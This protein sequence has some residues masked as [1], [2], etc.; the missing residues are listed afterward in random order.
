MIRETMI[1]LAWGNVPTKTRNN[2][3]I[4]LQCPYNGR[5]VGMGVSGT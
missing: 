3:S 1:A 4:H 2:G 5:M